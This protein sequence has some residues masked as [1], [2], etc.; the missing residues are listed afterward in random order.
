ML[1]KNDDG[2]LP[3]SPD[4]KHLAVIGE[5]ART[6]RFQG[7]GS[8]KVNPTRVDDALGAL[9]AA[10]A[11]D[12]TIDFAP[13]FANNRRHSSSRQMQPYSPSILFSDSSTFATSACR[14]RSNN[15]PPSRS[16]IVKSFG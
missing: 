13:G 8:S 16:K 6:P 7:A 1:L 10:V 11:D 4:V 2:L 3:L 12:V 15:T 14:P 9:R 5:F